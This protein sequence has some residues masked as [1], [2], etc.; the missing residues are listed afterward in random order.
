MLYRSSSFR[1][2]AITLTTTAAMLA[3]AS[4]FAVTHPASAQQVSSNSGS[5]ACASVT[6]AAKTAQGTA[7]AIRCEFNQSVLRT[8]QSAERTKAAIGRG[9]EEE[10]RGAGAEKTSTAA[11]DSVSCMDLVGKDI[12]A[13]KVK[14][15]LTPDMKATF[16]SRIEKCDRVSSL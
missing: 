8:Q 9:R 12:A 14:G 10:R 7:A 15:P 16:K 5:P 1:K 3:G 4:L 13:A 2:T 6:D 11:K